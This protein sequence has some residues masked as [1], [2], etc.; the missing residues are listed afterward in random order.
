MGEDWGDPF[1]ARAEDEVGESHD[2]L[3]RG[4]LEEQVAFA[5]SEGE[6]R[7]LVAPVEEPGHEKVLRPREDLEGDLGR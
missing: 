6:E 4:H 7:T 5:P 3:H 2:R 1:Q